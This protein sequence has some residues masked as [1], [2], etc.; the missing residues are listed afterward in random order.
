MNMEG[1][2]ESTMELDS[3]VSKLIL[4]IEQ[5]Q[6]LSQTA[7]SFLQ[8]KFL[9]QR[10]IIEN[11]DLISN[12]PN[13]L[14]LGMSLEKQFI[15]F[16]F[17]KI[18]EQTLE[19]SAVDPFIIEIGS[20][21]GYL[22][23]VLSNYYKK[24][25]FCVDLNKERLK[26]N[27]RINRL[28]QDSNIE[29]S[30]RLNKKALISTNMAVFH[31]SLETDADFKLILKSSRNFFKI[32]E[33]INKTLFQVS[34]VGL[35]LCG[36]LPYTVLDQVAK[37]HIE[38]KRN[39][40]NAHEESVDVCNVIL[41]PCCPDKVTQ[42]PKST[43]VRLFMEDELSGKRIAANLFE[44]CITTPI[45]LIDIYLYALETGFHHVEIVYVNSGRFALIA[46]I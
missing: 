21:K 25:T 29:V 39:V 16:T 45:N 11:N 43:K 9:T 7:E 23:R 37:N 8:T 36:D 2:L 14:K 35:H 30:T 28:V 27:L 44:G 13:S 18:V 40:F 3:L 24:K 5:E 20:G 34:I 4:Q 26:S 15:T 31:K 33:S 19:R 42:F 22:S 1:C 10:Q 41:V 12:I 32:R 17:A 46:S 6:A 38:S